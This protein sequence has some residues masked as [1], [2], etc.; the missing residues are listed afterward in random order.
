LKSARGRGGVVENI[1]VNNIVMRDIQKTAFIFNLFYD[2][3]TIVEQVTER[4]PIFRNIHISNVTGVDIYQVGALTGIE[5]MPVEEISL[6]NINMKAKQGFIAKTGK[7]LY[8]SN[9]D[10]ATEIGSSMEF[11]DCHELVLNNVRS[12]KPL[13]NEAIVEIQ[14]SSQVFINNCFQ[15]VPADIFAKITDSKVSKGN[16]Y[17][18][19]VKQAFVQK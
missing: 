18:G 19:N 14:S 17:L 1:R 3:D 5:E 6:T 9:I 13:E 15:M 11:T 12:G 4:T 16:N 2:K 10:I 7:N 8:F